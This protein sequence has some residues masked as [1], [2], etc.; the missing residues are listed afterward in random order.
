MG[1]EYDV[2]M[3][4]GDLAL[5]FLFFWLLVNIGFAVLDQL[6]TAE[7]RLM[8]EQISGFLSMNNFAPETFDSSHVFPKVSHILKII[9][10]PQLV[11]IKVGSSTTA[12]VPVGENLFENM[13][14]VTFT[15]RAPLGYTLS[16]MIKLGGSCVSG[17]CQL[18]SK[19]YNTLQIK[20]IGDDAS[21]NLVR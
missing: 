11:A 1:P 12:S 8:Q 21:V 18:S 9:E 16:D 6:Y 20:K 17:G 7:A 10:Q 5:I 3:M 2:V 14:R 15:P 19:E 13:L 4:V